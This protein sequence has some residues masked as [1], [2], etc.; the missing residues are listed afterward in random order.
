MLDESAHGLAWQNENALKIVL[1][2]A[3]CLMDAPLYRSTA[4]H[5]GASVAPFS[6]DHAQAEQT[7]YSRQTL[8]LLNMT[9]KASIVSSDI[10]LMNVV[11]KYA[12]ERGYRLEID[13]E[14]V[15]HLVRQI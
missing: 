14:A 2:F 1:G 15:A 3:L 9:L 6:A 10:H 13:D 12:K 8:M 5:L 7:L 4:E 11:L